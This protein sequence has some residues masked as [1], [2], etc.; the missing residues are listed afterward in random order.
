MTI[1]LWAGPLSQYLPDEKKD[2]VIKDERKAVREYFLWEVYRC[3]L[4][5]ISNSCYALT[6]GHCLEYYLSLNKHTDELKIDDSDQ[7]ILVMIDSK[8][9]KGLNLPLTLNKKPEQA[10][11]VAMGTGLGPA[12]RLSYTPPVAPDHEGTSTAPIYDYKEFNK[13][14]KNSNYGPLADWALIKL[15][16]QNCSC[17]PTG[18]ETPNGNVIMTGY[19]NNDIHTIEAKKRFP[20]DETPISVAEGIICVPDKT[21]KRADI[22]KLPAIRR[23]IAKAMHTAEISYQEK[24]LKETAETFK[25]QLIFHNAISGNGASGGALVNSRHELVG[26]NQGGTDFSKETDPFSI[27][28]SIEHIKKEIQKRVSP[29]EFKE[30]FSCDPKK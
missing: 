23:I 24:M 19:P 30:A 17:L 29:E 22:N 6:S 7:S 1:S 2:S 3:T 4:T 13:F 15:P 21:N 18:N 26:I 28:V 8:K 14:I 25:D 9:L 16:E 5:V 10:K 20:D 11:F 12:I 27:A